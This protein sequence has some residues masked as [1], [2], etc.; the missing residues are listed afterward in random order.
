MQGGKLADPY[1]NWYLTNP[2]LVKR[3]AVISPEEIRVKLKFLAVFLKTPIATPEHGLT[4]GLNEI[5]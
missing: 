1:L 4:P 3:C 5:T 2:N